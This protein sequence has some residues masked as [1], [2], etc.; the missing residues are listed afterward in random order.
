MDS[1]NIRKLCWAGR[2]VGIV[3][4]LK[5]FDKMYHCC[6]QKDKGQEA[7]GNELHGTVRHE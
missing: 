7:R 3:N 6:H 5:F 1:A 2:S 4:L